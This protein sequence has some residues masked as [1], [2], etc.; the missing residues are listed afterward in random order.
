MK[1]LAISALM[2]QA[3]LLTGCSV[4][5]TGSMPS[6]SSIQQ[7]QST[8]SSNESATQEETSNKAQETIEAEMVACNLAT[9]PWYSI[10]PDDMV[11]QQ[12]LVEEYGWQGS[13]TF[14]SDVYNDLD[15]NFEFARFVERELT[16]VSNPDS[17]LVQIANSL[18]Q[19]WEIARDKG[20]NYMSTRKMSNS[21]FEAYFVPSVTAMTEAGLKQLEFANRCLELYGQN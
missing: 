1:K 14:D 6:G 4:K 12:E 15:S 13:G 16:G 3:M 21:I 18:T 2:V 11:R 5:D 20:H 19:N 17:E 9:K 7:E 8:S 10:N